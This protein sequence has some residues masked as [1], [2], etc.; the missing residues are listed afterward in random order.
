MEKGEYRDFTPVLQAHRNQDNLYGDGTEKQEVIASKSGNRD[1]SRNRQQ[2]QERPGKDTS[3]GLLDA[4]NQELADRGLDYGSHDAR[5]S[6][7]RR[8]WKAIGTCHSSVN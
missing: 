2:K 5:K 1:V 3:R 4:E 7:F 6:A 8:M